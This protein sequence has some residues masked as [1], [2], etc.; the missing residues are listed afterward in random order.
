MSRLEEQL[1]ATHER[2]LGRSIAERPWSSGSSRTRYESW[3]YNLPAARSWYI[4]SPLRVPISVYAKQ[5]Y[6]SHLH[7]NANY[8]PPARLFLSA[9]SLPSFSKPHNLADLEWALHPGWKN[10]IVSP[11]NFSL[12]HGTKVNICRE[13]ITSAP[14]RGH[15][16]LESPVS[17]EASL[18]GNS[19][20]R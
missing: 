4:T 19:K 12:E 5:D 14:R 3:V 16:H 1:G 18:L 20:A 10:Q 8:F 2:T 9:Q 6:Q 13:P 7:R 15:Y 11:G 17:R